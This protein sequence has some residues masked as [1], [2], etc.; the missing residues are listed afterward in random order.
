VAV[1]RYVYLLLVPMSQS[2][3]HS[4]RTIDS[5]MDPAF[6][7]AVAGYVVLAAVL[8]RWRRRLPIEVLGIVWF[9]LLVA[10]SHVIPLQEALAEHRIYTASS[11]IF[12]AAASALQRLSALVGSRWQRQNLVGWAAVVVV[13]VLAVLTVA[14]NRVWADEV[15]LWSDAADNASDTWAAQYGLAEA[16]R[17]AGRCDEALTS[18]ERATELLP[19]R[20]EP[21]LNAGICLAELERFDEAR[22]SFHAARD[23]D[24]TSPKAHN[25]LGTLAA[26]VGRHDVARE[27]FLE[28]IRHD[29]ANVPARQLL[30]QLCEL[31]F[32]DP[33]AAMK[34]CQEIQAIAPWTPGAEQCIARNRKR[35]NGS[36]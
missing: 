4:V 34:L 19:K 16:Q 29:P 31:A 3:V 25:N 9:F 35:L 12:L 22:A 1:W 5:A 32:D 21:Y 14:R 33:G 15:T 26:R 13:V 17:Q 36:S 18:Y 6:V 20:I 11:G 27:H 24:P 10:P 30:A 28:A 8:Y 23:L 7:A 2:L